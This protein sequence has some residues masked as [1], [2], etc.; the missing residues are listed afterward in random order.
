MSPP[1]IV[2]VPLNL[3]V[4]WAVEAP[5]PIVRVLLNLT[6]QR[7]VEAPPAAALPQFL[8]PTVLPTA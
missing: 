7:A 6:L 2:G 8:C 4:S 5:S 3:T 1:P